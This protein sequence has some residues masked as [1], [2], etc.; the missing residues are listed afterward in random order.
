[1]IGAYANVNLVFPR[2]GECFHISDI[3]GGPDATTLSPDVRDH[4]NNCLSLFPT[5]VDIC[6]INGRRV[7][8][9]FQLGAKHFLP[10]FRCLF[11]MTAIFLGVNVSKIFFR[12][13]KFHSIVIYSELL[14]IYK[15]LKVYSYFNFTKFHF[16]MSLTLTFRFGS[17]SLGILLRIFYVTSFIASFH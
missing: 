2:I 8:A 9:N 11:S 3:E 10:D 6:T 7:I 14:V 17:Q 12:V 13:L 15:R 16:Q 5:I 4:Q 1:M